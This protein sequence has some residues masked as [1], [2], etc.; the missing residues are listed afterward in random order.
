MQT[1]LTCPRSV[2]AGTR[3]SQ[4]WGWDATSARIPEHE[5]VVAAFRLCV[6]CQLFKAAAQSEGAHCLHMPAF[7]PVLRRFRD[8]GFHDSGIGSKSGWGPQPNFSVDMANCMAFSFPAWPER[9]LRALPEPQK[10]VKEW[11]QASLQLKS[12][13]GLFV[14]ILLGS[15]SCRFLPRS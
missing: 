11:P 2:I 10:Y 5:L 3:P 13:K 15:G 7:L 9:K 1:L 6:W 12:P 8:P 4:G 14:K